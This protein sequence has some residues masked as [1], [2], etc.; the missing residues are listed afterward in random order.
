MISIE[1]D[2]SKYI[3]S[4]GA[5]ENFFKKIGYKEVG[6]KEAKIETEEIKEKAQENKLKNISKK[7]IKETKV[8]DKK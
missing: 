5:Y 1:K 6:K 4:K 2:G 8:G 3:V 7:V